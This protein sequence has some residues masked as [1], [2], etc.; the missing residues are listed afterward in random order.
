MTWETGDW[1]HLHTE[2]VMLLTDDVIHTKWA[3]Q[4]VEQWISTV[5]TVGPWPGGGRAENN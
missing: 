4:R 2:D 3:W 5:M 1:A